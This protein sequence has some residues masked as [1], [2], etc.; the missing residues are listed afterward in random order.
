[1]T[2][3]LI[4]LPVVSIIALLLG[5]GWSA[6][7][8]DVGPGGPVAFV[9][10][11][12]AFAIA[13]SSLV[14]AWAYPFDL[15]ARW[16]ALAIVIVC[17]SG[18]LVAAYRHR[19]PRLSEVGRS[20]VGLVVP[21]IV[22]LLALAPSVANLTRLSVGERIGPDATGYAISASAL[23]NGATRSTIEHALLTQ[24]GHG[25]VQQALSTVAVFRIPSQTV[26]FANT[27]MNGSDRWGFPGTAGSILSFIG[28]SHL[29]SLLSLLTAFALL[30]ACAG[31]WTS[32]IEAT[33]NRM[34][35]MVAVVLLGLS[36]AVL[37]NWHEGGLAE[38][39]VMPCVLLVIQPL[40]KLGESNRRG[41]I[42]GVG[43]GVAGVLPAFHEE[44][45]AYSLVFSAF[46]ILSLF[47]LNQGWWHSWWPI[48][49]GAISG[50]AIVAPATYQVLSTLTLSLGSTATGGWTMPRW[51][52][53]AEAFG[54][55]NP[56]DSP[57]L[58]LGVRTPLERIVDGLADAGIAVFLLSLLGRN[59]RRR[60]VTL[61]GA[62]LATGLAVYFK[63]RYIDHASNYQY[64]KAIVILAPAGALAI[65]HLIGEHLQRSSARL[66]QATRRLPGRMSIA[67]IALVLAV[68]VS[69]ISYIIDY[70]I[71]GSVVPPRYTTLA[72]STEVQNSFHRYNVVSTPGVA[73]LRVD[74]LAAE[75]DLNLLWGPRYALDF[76]HLGTRA[77]NPIA[78]LVLEYGCPRFACLAAVHR[79]DVILKKAGVALVRLGGTIQ[80][81]AKIPESD[82][83]NWAATHYLDEGGKLPRGAVVGERR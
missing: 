30:A 45:F 49:V 51:A 5:G 4:G 29:W 52:S 63:T 70:R 31:L 57:L 66:G 78:M 61:F 13:S 25:T 73:V 11:S 81:L 69:G 33:N 42:I 1:M 28:G 18:H 37:N 27:F 3:I 59:W 32:V 75:V 22:T 55:G 36:A 10:R 44:F 12:W 16:A 7:F 50:V 35:A 17:G 67:S 77:K 56:Y 71:Q 23:E 64:F 72:S 68:A 80:A 14:W 41:T 82:W 24:V 26:A 8:R 40:L 19:Y 20:L 46:M 74:A 83:Q 9:F 34:A 58:A 39:W 43:I 21:L 48:A 60:S 38:I 6:V 79:G 54:V 15:T 62:V 76:T 47:V 53:L 65:G 2:D